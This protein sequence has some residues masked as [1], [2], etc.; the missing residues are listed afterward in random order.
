MR[1]ASAAAAAAVGLSLLSEAPVSW[2]YSP[3]YAG[4]RMSAG[5]D[6]TD[7]RSPTMFDEDIAGIDQTDYY[8]APSTKIVNRP[9]ASSYERDYYPAASSKRVNQLSTSRYVRYPSSSD[10]NRNRAETYYRDNRSRGYDSYY[11][12]PP[13]SYDRYPDSIPGY[14][15]AGPNWTELGSPTMFDET[16]D[17]AD[18]TKAAKA[19]NSPWSRNPTPRPYNSRYTPRNFTNRVSSDKRDS[20]Y[21]F[22]GTW[23]APK[24]NR[25]YSRPRN[26]TYRS[27]ANYSGSGPSWA[28]NGYGAPGTFQDMPGSGAGSRR[29]VTYYD[30]G[31]TWANPRSEPVYRRSNQSWSSA[32]ERYGYG[33]NNYGS[34]NRM[35]WGEGFRFSDLPGVLG[36]LFGSGEGRDSRKYNDYNRRW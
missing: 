27:G 16:P 25:S 22:F 23:E 7:P 8:Q 14:R 24:A 12:R 32:G 28:D 31:P 15:S 20:N 1:V 35:A 36:R 18:V 33:N 2:A 26:R 9:P 29:G 13:S 30:S 4:D 19:A 21:R 3:N 17:S 11:E 5:P 34:N 6:W 10:Y